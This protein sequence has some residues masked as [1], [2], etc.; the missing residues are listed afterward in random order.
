MINSI[1]LVLGQGFYVCIIIMN[2]YVVEYD[3][4]R[5]LCATKPL[6]ASM[7]NLHRMTKSRTVQGHNIGDLTADVL[8]VYFANR[9]RSEGGK[10]KRIRCEESY[11]LVE[12]A[13]HE[14]ELFLQ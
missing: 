5:Q 3:H 14:S 13:E 11:A 6:R 7:M 12:F 4:L 9:Q 10:I 2:C 8:T 1:Q